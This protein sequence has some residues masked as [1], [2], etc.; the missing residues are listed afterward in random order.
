MIT[1]NKQRLAVKYFKQLTD[2]KDIPAKAMS[3]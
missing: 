1:T 2:M 3:I